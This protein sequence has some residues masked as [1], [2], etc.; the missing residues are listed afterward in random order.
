MRPLAFISVKHLHW[1]RLTAAT[2]V[3]VLWILHHSKNWRSLS[4]IQF[5]GVGGLSYFISFWYFTPSWLEQGRGLFAQVS[6][7]LL[8]L[9]W[10][11]LTAGTFVNVLWI[12][13]HSKNWRSLSIIQFYGVGGLSCFISFWYFT[14]SWLE[15]GRG[16]FAQV[17]LMLLHIF[18]F[19]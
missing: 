14:P 13:H 7:M 8:H 12:L 2:F 16:L 11:R 10:W 17:S 18:I 6:L 19:M 5:Y 9:H 3:N 1:W 15:Q 4:I